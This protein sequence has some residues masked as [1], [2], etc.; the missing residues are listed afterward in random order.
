MDE[1]PIELSVVMPCLNEADTIEICISK[2]LRAMQAAGVVGEV[3]VAD[4]G[5]TDSSVQIATALGARVAHVAEPG[6][7]AALMGGIRISRG[8]FVIMGMPTIVMIS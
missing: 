6:Y 2:A 7:G 3:I 1:Y 8:K 4:N 5:S